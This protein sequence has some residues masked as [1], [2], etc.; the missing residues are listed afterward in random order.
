MTHLVQAERDAAWAE[1]AR[2]LAHEIKNPLTPIQF[3]AERIRHKYLKQF[4]EEQGRVLERGTH[5]IV[6]QV[7][8]M[9]EM[10]DAFNEYARS[11][12]LQLAPLEL[13]EFVAE[14]L[15]LYRDYPAGVEIKLE[16][17]QEPL[18][19]NA[20]KVRLRQLLHNLVKN[21][22]E[23]IRDGHGSTLWIGA[24]RAPCR[25]GRLR[26]TERARRWAGIPR[27]HSGQRLRTVCDYQT[28]GNRTRIG[29]CQEN[30]RG[31]RRLDPVGIAARRRD[32]DRGPTA[33]I[34]WW[35]RIARCSRRAI[36]HREGDRMNA[37]YILVV[38][39]EP[40]IRDLVKEI[41]EDE[42]YTV[43]TAENA[44]AAREARRAQRPDLILLDIWMPDIDGISLLKEWS[45]DDHL[46]CPVI[47]MSGHGTVETAVEATRLGAYDFIEKPLS[48][49]KLLL[50][51]ER[52]LEAD[53]LAR[54]NQNLRR[55]QRVVAE[56]VGR[57][58]VMQRLRDQGQSIAQH[59]TW[60]LIIGE[61][62]SGKEVFAR[63]LHAQSPRR[64]RPVRGS[65]A[66]APSP[67]TTPR[68]AVRLRAGRADSLRPP[69]AGQRRHPVPRRGGRH[70]PG[71]PGQA[72][73]RAG[74]RLLPARRR[75]RTGAGRTCGSSPPPSAIWRRR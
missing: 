72:G 45:E 13:N 59:D 27:P 14:V 57:S 58:E 71:S 4:D 25:R 52:A 37:P 16:L 75:Q 56:P 55:Q 50:T 34:A 3:A 19:I 33:A 24:R 26:R 63:Y 17:A 46:P 7:Q 48:M 38:D 73:Q 69:G 18:P 22:I 54:E 5:T 35:R 20:D 74:E 65:W 29:D 70:G 67:A 31:A 6:Q 42:G 41:L 53:R 49:A 28:Q 21:A 11:P 15:Y 1:V 44:A 64:D 60:V 61:P 30:R 62:G 40:D 12:R 47:M 23:A 9:K 68:G 39:D 2:R 32:A 8:A 51:V 43:A 66:S 10:V 36:A